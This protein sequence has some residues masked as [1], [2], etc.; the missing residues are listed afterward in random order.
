MSTSIHSNTSMST[1]SILST[2]WRTPVLEINTTGIDGTVQF[3]SCYSDPNDYEVVP[4][5]ICA[6]LLLIG[7]VYLT[8]GYRCFKAVLF[9]T[10]FAFGTTVIYMICTTEHLLPQLGNI[11]VSVVAGL[12]FGLITVL[13][14]YVGLFMLGFHLGLLSTCATLVVVYILSPYID[15]I[16]APNSV[17]LVF[18]LFMGSGLVGSFAT[19]YFQRGEA[20]L[21]IPFY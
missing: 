21:S 7:I 17:W 12:L 2:T 20:F 9:L 4:S 10:G 8:Y 5:I 19:L 11:S 15:S 1:T 6:I 14:V 3:Y 18:A 13:V 16:E